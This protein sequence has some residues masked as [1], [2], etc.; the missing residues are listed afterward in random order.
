MNAELRDMKSE[1]MRM[2]KCRYCGKDLNGNIEFCSDE[3]ESHYKKAMEKDELKVKYFI[4]GIILGFLV[5]FY[6]IISNSRFLGGMGSIVMGIDV[7]LFP[8]TTPETTAFLGYQ[9]S[10]FVGRIAGIL[11]TAVGIWMGII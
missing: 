8:F 9:K 5:M 7:V 10:K 6:G 2:K 11:L 1:G 3:C 4:L